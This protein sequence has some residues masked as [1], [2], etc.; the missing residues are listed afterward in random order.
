M[1][2]ISV[3]WRNEWRLGLIVIL[4]DFLT[5]V[6]LLGKTGHYN[7][8][9]WILYRINVWTAKLEV[10]N[11]R[12]TGHLERKG[13]CRRLNWFL[14]INKSI[15]WFYQVAEGRIYFLKNIVLMFSF[16]IYSFNYILNSSLK[17][18]GLGNNLNKK[19]TKL[20]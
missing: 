7:F 5:R 18:R 15:N 6:T 2:T 4:E 9:T 16:K 14:H 17:C 19:I 8:W 10:E 1:A 3:I 11:S 13:Y 20:F 12:T